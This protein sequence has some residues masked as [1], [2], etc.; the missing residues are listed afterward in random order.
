MPKRKK[1]QH[2]IEIHDH[3]YT[4]AVKYLKA[5]PEFGNVDTVLRIA[6]AEGLELLAQR[7]QRERKH[8]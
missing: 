8:A 5:R 4:L 6:L 2:K 1:Q 3:F 7:E